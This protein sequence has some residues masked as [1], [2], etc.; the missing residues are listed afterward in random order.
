MNKLISEG[1]H[2]QKMLNYACIQG[3]HLG[4]NHCYKLMSEQLQNMINIPDVVTIKHDGFNV[5][6]NNMVVDKP[7]IVIYDESTYIAFKNKSLELVIMEM[8]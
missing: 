8:S 1:L 2:L 3:F 4:I 5:N 7:Y 6:L